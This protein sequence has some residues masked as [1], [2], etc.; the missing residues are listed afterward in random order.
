MVLAHRVV[1]R[2]E[3]LRL[4]VTVLD[5]CH[6]QQVLEA[7]F[8]ET[9]LLEQFVWQKYYVAV[10][11]VRTV[12]HS[13]M[14]RRWGQRRLHCRHQLL[15]PASLKLNLVA[16]QISHCRLLGISLPDWCRACRRGF[17]ALPWQ[18]RPLASGQ[19]SMW[20]T[21]R[22]TSS[23]CTGVYTA[24]A[25]LAVA[26]CIVNDTG[27]FRQKVAPVSKAVWDWVSV[28]WSSDCAATL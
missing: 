16:L 14:R 10:R 9:G 12:M 15:L 17:A 18:L 26:V 22:A 13:S 20:T 23:M 1:C 24:E 3:A 11:L 27:Y 5:D 19:E 21:V 4:I 2:H 6:R 28:S 7:S 8:L 25:A